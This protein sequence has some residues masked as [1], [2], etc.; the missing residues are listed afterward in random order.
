M[1]HHVT[2]TLRA[3]TTPINDPGRLYFIL[4]YLSSTE[5]LGVSTF[6]SFQRLESKLCHPHT[7]AVPP[8]FS[9]IK[10]AQA[11]LVPQTLRF[12]HYATASPA[13]TTTPQHHGMAANGQHEGWRR[14]CGGNQRHNPRFS[15]FNA[16]LPSPAQPS[17]ALPRP[18]AG[19][20]QHPAITSLLAPS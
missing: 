8:L 1:H 5:R 3:H 6:P 14:P 13:S 12:F 11:G 2:C 17:P 9:Q 10:L 7:C 18:A 19:C 16:L 20:Q 15:V 4:F